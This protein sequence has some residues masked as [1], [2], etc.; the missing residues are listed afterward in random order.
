MVFHASGRYRFTDTSVLP[1]AL[2]NKAAVVM[3]IRF[4]ARR[5]AGFLSMPLKLREKIGLVVTSG[6]FAGF[7]REFDR[8]SESADWARAFSVFASWAKTFA[9][10]GIRA[11]GFLTVRCVREGACTRF[12]AVVRAPGGDEA[13]F[14]ARRSRA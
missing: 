8:T 5:R 9:S 11:V 7:G 4:H 6:R 2:L 14:P 1:S 10:Q 3:Q 13:R 12:A